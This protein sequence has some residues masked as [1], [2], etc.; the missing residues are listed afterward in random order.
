M[1]VMIFFLAEFL[2]VIEFSC[3]WL[4]HSDSNLQ[5][6][7]GLH[8]SL[9]K[10]Q[11]LMHT[12]KL[13][14]PCI[15]RAAELGPPPPQFLTF[16]HGCFARIIGCF[17][18]SHAS[19]SIVFLFHRHWC[20]MWPKFPTIKG[21]V[22]VLGN[23]MLSMWEIWS[24]SVVEKLVSHYNNLVVSATLQLGIASIL[25]LALSFFALLEYV[26]SA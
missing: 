14:V 24:H 18:A 9:L 23:R 1:Y 13:L 20:I 12:I 4:N 26:I 16:A 10:Q 11:C 8:I 25:I 15:T 2:V 19:P 7:R 22:G 3:F 21:L 5:P 6:P 17:A